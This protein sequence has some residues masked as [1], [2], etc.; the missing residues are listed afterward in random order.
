[1]LSVYAPGARG[2]VSHVDNCGPDIDSRALSIVYYPSSSMPDEGGAL[3]LFP[4]HQTKEIR[5]MPT[6]DR[7]VLF[8]SARVPHAVE[9]RASD[10]SRRIAA[11]FWFLGEPLAVMKDEENGARVE[12]D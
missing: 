4:G 6:H 8:A 3:V 1:M 11:S 12:R 10:A 2:F 5:L 9:P 7:L